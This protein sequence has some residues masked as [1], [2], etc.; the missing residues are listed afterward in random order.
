M[1]GGL[2]KQGMKP[3]VALY[4]TFL[5]RGYDQILQ[6]I[7]MLHLPVVLA[8]DRA[9]LVGEDG[10]THHGVFDVGFLS[11]TPGMQILCP[12]TTAQLERMLRWAVKE[13]NGPVAIRYPRGGNGFL[14][15]DGWRPDSDVICH[16]RGK[17]GAIVTYGVLTNQA[18]EAVRLLRQRGKEITVLQLTRVNPVNIQQLESYLPAD[19]PVL[20]AEEAVDGIATDLAYHLQENVRSRVVKIADL[21]RQFVTHGA[22][23]R[24]YESCGLSADALANLFLEVDIHEN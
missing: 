4:S 18:L 2:A 22:V 7:A 9:G 21:G 5:Q 6:D 8:I 19:A 10:E 16:Q 12:A 17:D 1:A 24:L 20:I 3:V 23:S 15:C 11:Q 13:C 14:S